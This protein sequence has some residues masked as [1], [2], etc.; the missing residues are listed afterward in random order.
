MLM[1]QADLKIPYLRNAILG[2][3]RFPVGCRTPFQFLVKHPFIDANRAVLEKVQKLYSCLEQ[4]MD[5]RLFNDMNKYFDKEPPFQLE[6]VLMSGSLT[7]GTAKMNFSKLDNS[8]LD[9]MCILKNINVSENDQREGNLQMKDDSPFVN[10]YISDDSLI[11]IWTNFMETSNQSGDDRYSLS[12]MKL[13]EKLSENYAEVGHFFNDYVEEQAE[14]VDDGPA[15]QV[16]TNLPETSEISF[17]GLNLTGAEESYDFVLAINCEGWPL[18]AQEWITRQRLWPTQDVIEK[19]AEEN[20][21][22]VCKSSAEGKFRLSFSN[23]ELLLIQNLSVLQHQVYR[24]FKSF[25]NHYKYEWS[26]NI[27]K[28]LCSYHLKTLVLW[29]CE[30]TRTTDWSE[31]TIVSHLLALIDELVTALRKKNLPMYFMPKYNLLQNSEDGASV[32]DKI[33]VLRHDIFKITEAI[34]KEEPS[35]D[36]AQNIAESYIAEIDNK[37]QEFLEAGFVS[38]KQMTA[39]A[40]HMVGD[41]LEESGKMWTDVTSHRPIP[42]DENVLLQFNEVISDGSWAQELCESLNLVMSSGK[43]FKEMQRLLESS[44]MSERKRGLEMCKS[45]AVDESIWMNLN[46]LSSE[47]EREKILELRQIFIDEIPKQEEKMK[48]EQGEELSSTLAKLVNFI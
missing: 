48:Q 25:V 16:L 36:K 21:H 22:I 43:K 26:P 7:E 1:A 40:R 41:V 24:A 6:D 4:L 32:A 30:K 5:Q 12:P 31:D 35:R 17:L 14:K 42:V 19:I 9:L 13:K 10:L 2:I 15:I 45:A 28:I 23:A 44:E 29:H 11:K 38:E 47:E 18:C 34:N 3:L 8:D 37:S 33:D 27:K 20:F 46:E 39:F